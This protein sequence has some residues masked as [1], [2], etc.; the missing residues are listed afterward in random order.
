MMVMPS[1]SAFTGTSPGGFEGE[2]EAEPVRLISVRVEDRAGVLQRITNCLGRRGLR[3]HSC[4]VGQSA[5]DGVLSLWLRVA[6]GAQPADQV[7]KQLSKLIDVVSVEDLTV[8]APHEWTL[9]LVEFSL[10]GSEELVMA[11]VERLRAQVVHCGRG[12]LVAAISGP[13]AV[14]EAALEQL[15]ILP[16]LNWVCSRPMALAPSAVS[17]AGEGS[18]FNSQGS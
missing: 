14:V 9:A 7:V 15:R 8:Q 6:T 2:A 10:A 18:Q 16:V 3:L 1:S 13:P 5:E 4:S 17:D 11:A 12:R